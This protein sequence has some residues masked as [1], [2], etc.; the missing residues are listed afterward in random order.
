LFDPRVDLWD[1]HF[2]LSG[3]EIVGKTDIGLATIVTL[4]LNSERRIFIREAELS[5]GLFPP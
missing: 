1:D 2:S 5:F 3:F 4:N